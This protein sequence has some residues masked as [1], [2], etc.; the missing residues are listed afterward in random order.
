[1][2]SFLSDTSRFTLS[3]SSRLTITNPVD[4][5]LRSQSKN[6]DM[7]QSLQQKMV[8]LGKLQ[9][10]WSSKQSLL[11]DKCETLVDQLRETQRRST[12]EQ[13]TKRAQ[14]L[15]TLDNMV[16]KHQIEVMDLQTQINDAVTAPDTEDGSVIALDQEIESLKMQIEAFEG[17]PA[18]EAPPIDVEGNEEKRGFLEQRI[19]ELKRVL[20][21]ATR[22]KEEDSKAATQ[23]LQQLIVANQEADDRNQTEIAACVEELNEIERQQVQQVTSIEKEIKDTRAGLT[24]RLKDTVDRASEMQREVSLLH[25]KQKKEMQS[26]MDTAGKLRRELAGITENQQRNMA[27]SA[28]VVKRTNDARRDFT[29]LHKE[30]EMLNAELARETIERETL[31]KQLQ[32]MDDMVITQMTE[33]V[34]GSGS[35][36]SFAGF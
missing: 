21:D 10:S 7:R 28:Q 8:D 17:L 15:K 9:T 20:E 5:N 16:Q 11:N 19:I 1:M 32:K 13:S 14:H 25:S 18:P 29:A 4:P 35:T 34:G 22:K 24:R 12:V 23:M 36:F 31:M 2:S 26:F 6:Q 3:K 27:E 30:L 33:S